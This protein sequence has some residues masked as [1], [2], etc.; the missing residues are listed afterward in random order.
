MGC[1]TL[2]WLT[3]HLWQRTPILSLT[4][5]VSTTI[6]LWNGWNPKATKDLISFLHKMH[7]LW[8][9]WRSVS[10]RLIGVRLGDPERAASYGASVLPIFWRNC[11]G[12]PGC[13]HQKHGRPQKRKELWVHKLKMPPK[14]AGRVSWAQFVACCRLPVAVNYVCLPWG[15]TA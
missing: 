7:P 9:V 1:A 14:S 6:G 5:V 4:T 15:T 3:S 13:E 2:Q 12:N 11:S 8:S 10:Y